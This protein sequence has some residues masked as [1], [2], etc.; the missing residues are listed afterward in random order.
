MLD[1]FN[2]FAAWLAHPEVRAVLIGLIISWNMTQLIKNAPWLIRK[3]EAMRVI[4][5]R[6]LALALAAV[7]TAVLWPGA[8][9]ESVLVGGAVGLAAPTIYTYGA[10]ILYHFFPWLEVKMSAMPSAAKAE[11]E[12]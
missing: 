5:T 1:W 2:T 6:L 11:R 12:S 8:L 9:A 7:P 3:R 4:L 10:R